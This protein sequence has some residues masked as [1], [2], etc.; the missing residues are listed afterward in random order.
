MSS[1]TTPARSDSGSSAVR[2]G[3]RVLRRRR[4][5]ERLDRGRARACDGPRVLHAVPVLE[6]GQPAGPRRGDGAGDPRRPPRSDAL[7]RRDGDGRHAAGPAAALHAHDRSIQVVAA[8]PELGDLVYGLRSLDD[9]FV[10]PIFDPRG[11]PEVPGARTTPCGRPRADVA[12]GDCA[13]ISSGAVLHVAQRI[14]AEQD[15][16]KIVCLLADGGWKY[17]STEAWADDLATADKKV[18][19][20]LWWGAPR[21]R[22]AC[23]TP[24]WAAPRWRARSSTSSRTSP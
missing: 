19:G 20:A 5:D 23:S 7:R 24:G 22:S 6:P 12:G 18:S 14:A 17:L 15:R 21:A 10:P 9:G 1:R 16:A 2:R 13:G 11:G 8:E 3:D 4:G